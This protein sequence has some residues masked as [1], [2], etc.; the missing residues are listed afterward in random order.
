MPEYWRLEPVHE[1]CPERRTCK[2]HLLAFIPF[3]DGP[4]TCLG[5]RFTFLE[6]KLCLTRLINEYRILPTDGIEQ[7]LNITEQFVVVLKTSSNEFRMIID[8]PHF[9]SKLTSCIHRQYPTKNVKSIIQL[10]TKEFFKLSRFEL[11]P[12]E[13]IIEIFQ[14]IPLIDLFNGFVNLN[15]RL[16]FILRYVR[17]GVFLHQ[18]EY[19]NKSLLNA[20]YYFSK[21]ILYIHVDYYPLLNLKYFS[22][23]HS[24]TIYLPTRNQLL[25]IN[26]HLMPNLSRLWIGIINRKDQKILFNILFEDE[27]F[28]KL[29]FCNLFEINLYNNIYPFKSCK[30]IR[31]LLITNCT[32]KDF[33]ILLS[34]LPNLYQLEICITDVLSTSSHNLTNYYHEKLRILKIE[35]SQKVSQLNILNCLISFVPY[36]QRCTLLLANLFKIR[37]YAHLQNILIGNLVELREFVC[38]IDY[39]CQLSSNEMIPK[40]DRLRIKLPFFQ[41]MRVIPCIKHHEKCARRTWMNKTLM[42]IC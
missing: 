7:K 17:L 39:Y 8:M 6:I 20:L 33:V 31:T 36:V 42:P 2:R 11:M 32:T 4:R 23:L 27:Q 21:Q 34:L 19:T 28:F 1:F 5:M 22:N 37:D 38:S 41:T 3:G 9:L 24:L 35:F 12:D 10:P 14:Y 26:S 15:F 18:N 29:N 30:N 13:L 25:S 40:F 16:N